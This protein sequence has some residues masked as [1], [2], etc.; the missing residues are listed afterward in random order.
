MHLAW[1][2]NH[3]VFLCEQAHSYAFARILEKGRKKIISVGLVVK[4]LAERYLRYG[5]IILAFQMLAAYL[6]N[7]VLCLLNPFAAAK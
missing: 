5:L 3:S 2:L 4:T 1:R 7:V 6:I